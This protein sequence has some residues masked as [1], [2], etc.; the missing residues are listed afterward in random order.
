MLFSDQ[1]VVVIGLHT[2]FEHH[3][4]MGADALEVF[5]HEYVLSFPIGIDQPS[6]QGNI[7]LTMQAYGLRGTP[8]RGVLDWLGR[9]RLNHFGHIDDFRIGALLRANSPAWSARCEQNVKSAGAAS[10]PQQQSQAGRCQRHI[11]RPLVH[12]SD[13][14]MGH[15]TGDMDSASVQCSR[16]TPALQTDWVAGAICGDIALIGLWSAPKPK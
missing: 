9:I 1:E 15:K 4:V 5:V 8:S 13:G 6:V 2:V 14:F 10:K 12:S 3:A 7:P 11:A 16:R